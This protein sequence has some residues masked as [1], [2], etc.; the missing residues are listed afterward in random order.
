MATDR[1][2]DLHAFRRLIDQQLEQGGPLPTLDQA[3][4]A[5]WEYENASEEEREEAR[6]A[7]G[8]GS[9]GSRRRTLSANRGI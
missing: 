8:Q 3:A 2:N 4:L 5:R 9:C 6:A 1:A 7:I